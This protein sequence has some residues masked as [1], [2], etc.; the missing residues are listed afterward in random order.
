EKVAMESNYPVAIYKAGRPYLCGSIVFTEDT[1]NRRLDYLFKAWAPDSNGKCQFQSGNKRL[2]AG[3]SCLKSQFN[4]S[5]KIEL[6]LL[7]SRPEGFRAIDLNGESDSKN[8]V[9]SRCERSSASD[10]GV[11]VTTPSPLGIE[12]E[13][14]SFPNEDISMTEENVSYDVMDM[15]LSNGLTYKVILD[16]SAN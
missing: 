15:K 8:Q 6:S 1:S 2:L 11:A 7:D 3:N 9:F 5:P 4:R 14:L 16:Q 13:A 12:L 10:P